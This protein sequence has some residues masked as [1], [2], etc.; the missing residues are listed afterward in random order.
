MKAANLIKFS[1]LT[2]QELDE[3]ARNKTLNLKKLPLQSLR[4]LCRALIN[5]DYESS[6]MADYTQAVIRE[7]I[8]RMERI[9][10]RKAKREA[11]G[12]KWA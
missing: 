5:A 2:N 3:L 11:E 1:S 9:E 10:K 6:F 7:N 4:E 8:A 12:K